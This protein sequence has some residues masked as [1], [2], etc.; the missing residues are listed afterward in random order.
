VFWSNKFKR[1]KQDSQNRLRS[2]ITG[3]VSWPD[4]KFSMVDIIVF[5]STHK[6]TPK[7]WNAINVIFEHNIKNYTSGLNI[8]SHIKQKYLAFS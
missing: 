6:P 8:R 5:Y 2:H 3:I 1:P 7:I 4:Y